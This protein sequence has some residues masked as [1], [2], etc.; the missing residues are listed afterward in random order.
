M[1]S[2]PSPPLST[3]KSAYLFILDC[4][5]LLQCWNSITW[6][7]IKFRVGCTILQPAMYS[8]SNAAMWKISRLLTNRHCLFVPILLHGQVYVIPVWCDNLSENGKRTELKLGRTSNAG[9]HTMCGNAE[10][11]GHNVVFWPYFHG[12]GMMF[13]CI[14]CQLALLVASS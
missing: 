4:D 6:Y 8:Q 7:F 9:W 10:S 12:C 11:R 14:V 2:T 3:K 13:P 5:T 1:G